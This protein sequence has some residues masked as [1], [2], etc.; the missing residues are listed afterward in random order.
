MFTT[1][2]GPAVV[3]VMNYYSMNPQAMAIAMEKLIKTAMDSVPQLRIDEL[4]QQY[5]DSKHDGAAAG[6]VCR[7]CYEAVQAGGLA[8][9]TSDQIA[10]IV[11]GSGGR[12]IPTEQTMRTEVEEMT[13]RLLNMKD[14]GE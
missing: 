11:S 2:Y 6:L 1:R 14:E 9:E 3:R 4:A 10:G 7:K 5:C 13:M 8:P 12:Q